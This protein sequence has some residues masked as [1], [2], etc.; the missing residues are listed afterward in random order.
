MESEQDAF[1][2]VQK[3]KAELGIVDE[4]IVEP[5]VETP[6]EK[7]TPAEVVPAKEDEP[8]PEPVSARALKPEEGKELKQ[9]KAELQEKLQKDFDEKFEK[10]KAEV[11]TAKPSETK[12]ENLEEDIK[13]LAKELN[14]D[15]E[16]TRKIILVA[17]KGVELSPEDKTALEEFKA[18][19]SQREQE[20]VQRAERE[21][22]QI[23]N[24]EFSA[25][26]PSIKTQYP[27]ATDEQIAQ[28]K[29]Q[30]DEL[31]HSEK[32]HEMDMDYILFKEREALGKILFSPRM[33]TFEAGRP[34]MVEAETDEF[35]DFDPN[36]TPAQFEAFEKRR[37][38]AVDN[39]GKE[40]IRITTRDDRGNVIEREE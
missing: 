14:F 9:F 1:D 17:R 20:A 2:A 6:E 32:Y 33:K 24:E 35:P 31:A 5:V 21:Q 18:T 15:E 3:E 22:E 36:M 40:K 8:A 13:A 19:R 28:A 25:V 34:S 37:E 4:P 7:E 27:N 26:L 30:L 23:F 38:R 29:A 10:L 39:S 16:K 12:V 11:A